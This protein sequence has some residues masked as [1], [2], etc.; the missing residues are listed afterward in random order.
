MDRYRAEKP[1]GAVGGVLALV[2]RAAYAAAWAIVRFGRGV[3]ITLSAIAACVGVAVIG[4]TWEALRV[5]PDDARDLWNGRDRGSVTVLDRNGGV[6][7]VRGDQFHPLSLQDAGD[8]LRQAVLST[9]DRRFFWHLGVDPIGLARALMV[10]WRAGRTE[11]GG[12]SITQQVSKLAFLTNERRLGR[13]LRE[14]PLSLALEW[15]FSKAEILEIYLNRA[16]LGAGNFGFRAAAKFYFEKEP[17]DLS[18]AEAALLAGLLRAPSK[19]SPLSDF[20]S[21]QDRARIVLDAMQDAGAITAEQ[22]AADLLDLEKLRV[23]KIYE[24][25]SY[26]VDWADTQVP[27]GI[28]DHAEDVELVTTLDPAAQAYSEQAIANVFG[29]G[30]VTPRDY[31]A[32][33]A[34]VVLGTDGS[35]RAMVGGRDYV[36]SQY[37]RAAQSR[38]QLGSAFKPFVYAAALHHGVSPG[39]SV[40]DAPI[41]IGSWSPKNYAGRYRGTVPLTVAL[42]KSSNVASVRLSQR[43]GVK[44]VVNTAARFGFSGVIPPYPSVALG[45]IETNPLE[46]A[47]AYATIAN[48]GALTPAFGV[49]EIRKRDGDV[50]WRRKAPPKRQAISSTDAGHLVRMMRSVVTQGTGRR[51]NMGERAV[52]GKTGTTQDYKDAWF[53]GFTGNYVAVAWMGRD[54]STS[55]NRITGGRVPAQIWRETM[56]PLHLYQPAV[57]LNERSFGR[58]YSA[59]DFGAGQRRATRRAKPAQTL[60]QRRDA[61]RQLR[62]QSRPSWR[63]RR[64][65]SIFQRFRNRR[66]RYGD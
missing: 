42:A 64:S 23:P 49:T 54:D 39:G 41:R 28:W 56:D 12:S 36:E 19:W 53:A 50:I 65:S 25:A 11:Q 37:N 44:N 32:E 21:A 4:A 38:R 30:L 62:S 48:G 26:F 51:A 27:D 35:I 58:T 7:G 55:M 10:N 13:K 9:E 16:Y 66:N 15:R 59:R 2:S 46:V 60:V 31:S 43:V 63:T 33:A 17:R 20:G 8:N 40:R 29:S 18:R 5:I 1:R 47:S 61:L 3:L 24:M 22:R 52:A 34:V 14:V 57:A 6:L 45:V